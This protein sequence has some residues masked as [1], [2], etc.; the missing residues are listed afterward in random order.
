MLFLAILV[1]FTAFNYLEASLPALISMIAPAGNKGAAMGI[2][3][4]FQFMGAFCGGVAGGLWLNYFSA[5]GLFILVVILL[6]IWFTLAF[7]MTE[8]SG[9]RGVC[10]S[11]C[12]PTEQQAE[13]LLTK[14]ESLS[15]VEEAV[16][17]F[18]EQTAYLK[19]KKNEFDMNQALALTASSSQ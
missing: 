13:P 4:S 17:I 11:L 1:Y 16:I 19:V 14:L 18:D 9:I 15:G 5:Q 6:L 8:R 3:S 12:I 2:Y 10:L 7:G